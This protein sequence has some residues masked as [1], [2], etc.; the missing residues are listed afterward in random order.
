MVYLS[1]GFGPTSEDRIKV[2]EGKWSIRLTED[3]KNFLLKNNGGKPDLAK[4]CFFDKNKNKNKNKEDES[5]VNNFYGLC[6]E[7]EKR[8]HL[9]LDF[10]MKVFIDRFPVKAIP[11]ASDVFGNQLI[12]VSEGESYGKVYFFDHEYEENN[13]YLVAENV[14]ELLNKLH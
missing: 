13:L 2:F 10:K 12:V 3:Y 9:S 6:G 11:I 8:S 4:F 14:E 7:K 5:V 1:D